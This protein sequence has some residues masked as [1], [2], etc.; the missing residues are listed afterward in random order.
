M[1]SRKIYHIYC[2]TD[3]RLSRFQSVR[4]NTAVQSGIKQLALVVSL[5]ATPAVSGGL[6]FAIGYASP[7]LILDSVS[8]AVG[9][10]LLYTVEA[11]TTVSK[12][13][14]VMYQSCVGASR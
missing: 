5:S 13:Y 10:G 11:D 1:V 12:L 7:F 8:S 2:H 6:V 9:A 4:G 14:V 3:S